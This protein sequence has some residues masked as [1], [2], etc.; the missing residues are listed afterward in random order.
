MNT[1]FSGV[2]D[3]IIIII[4]IIIIK[5]SE[6][7]Q[8]WVS[9]HI[10]K[11]IAFI[12]WRMGKKK[13]LSHHT[14]TYFYTHPMSIARSCFRSPTLAGALFG[15][16][17]RY[18]V[19]CPYQAVV[20]ASHRCRPFFSTVLASKFC[21]ARG[22]WNSTARRFSSSELTHLVALSASQLVHKKKS[23]QIC[24]NMHSGGLELTKLT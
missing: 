18:R 8:F 10:L 17:C 9:S 24:T 11:L 4:I 15:S 2:E 5:R 3:F 22:L 12:L 21:H 19:S 13:A 7:D 14:S 23:I 1:I 6:L 20:P 16:H